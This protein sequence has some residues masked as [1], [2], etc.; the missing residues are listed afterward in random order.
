LDLHATS[1]EPFYSDSLVAP[2]ETWFY[3]VAAFDDA[4][5]VSE[6]SEAAGARRA[7][8]VAPG[9]S[10]AIRTGLSR[11]LPN[12]FNPHTSIEYSLASTGEVVLR[13]FDATGSLVRT[14]V[15]ERQGEV[16]VHHAAWDGRDD[17]GRPVASGTYLAELRSAGERHVIKL[18]LVR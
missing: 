8:A 2:G 16:G 14:L 1:T 13:V 15:S 11:A 9:R 6:Y 18:T 17:D 4:G 10:R 3:R 12:P 5:N 7:T